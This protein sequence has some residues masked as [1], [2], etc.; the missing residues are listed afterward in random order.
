MSPIDESS[1]SFL[2]PQLPIEF[3]FHTPKFHYLPKLYLTKHHLKSQ[4]I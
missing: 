3:F 4:N 1:C 2:K